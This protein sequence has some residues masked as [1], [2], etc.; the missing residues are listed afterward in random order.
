MGAVSLKKEDGEV[1][2]F[3]AGEV[4]EVGD[5][6]AQLVVVQ[7]KLLQVRVIRE[8]GDCPAQLVVVQPK[9]L[10]AGETG[11]IGD[12]PVQLVVVQEKSR[13]TAAFAT[14]AEPTTGRSCRQP[15]GVAYP[16]GAVGCVV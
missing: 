16:M 11:E 1:K 10:Q 13:D 2:V 4:G 5:W 6:P 8:V 3:Q 15:A 12:W 9:V 14:Y 7:Y